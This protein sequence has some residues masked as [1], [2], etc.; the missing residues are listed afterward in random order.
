MIT[1]STVLTLSLAKA[2]GVYMIAGG[3][4]GL[5]ARDR[6]AAILDSF[7]ENAGLTYMSGLFVFALGAVVILAHNTWTDPL[8]IVVSLF[9][10]VAAIEGVVIIAYP[11]PL[12]KWSASM[13]RPAMVT[14]FAIFTIVAGAILLLLGL[15][16]TAGL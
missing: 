2:M 13:L 6:W 16:G 15:T 14:G 11:D 5:L 12:L 3:L 9:G 4:S 10:W 7:R 1:T 8:A